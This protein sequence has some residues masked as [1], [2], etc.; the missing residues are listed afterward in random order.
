MPFTDLM[1]DLET[2][3]TRPETGVPILAIGWCAWDM[4][5]EEPGA[6]S[7]QAFIKDPPGE[8]DFDTLAWWGAQPS[9]PRLIAA[10]RDGVTLPQALVALA[11]GVRPRMRVWSHG[12]TFDAAILEYWY[13][14]LVIPTPW[15]FWDV[16]DTR[17]LYDVTGERLLPNTHDAREDAVN[18]AKLVWTCWRRLR[19][20]K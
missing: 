4:L 10:C 12:A 6:D 3:G 5:A 1:I 11:G 7:G 17:T 14:R 9:W 13:R 16:R 20:V 18:Q 2:L 8:I 15:K 19:G